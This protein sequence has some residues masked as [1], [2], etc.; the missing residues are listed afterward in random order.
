M[1]YCSNCGSPIDPNIKFCTS[2]GAANTAAS[3]P[4]VPAAAPVAPPPVPTSSA[5][6]PPPAPVPAPATPAPA[7]PSQ[8]AVAAPVN[9]E[10]VQE[11]SG[12]IHKCP[13]CGE[14]LKALAAKCPA[15]GF[16]LSEVSNTSS[17]KEFSDK[18]AKT[19]STNQKI[20]LIRNFP[21]PNAKAD[22][23][24]FL[25]LATSNFDTKKHM[26]ATGSQRQISEAWLSKIEQAYVKAQTLF[27][28][29]KDFAKFQELYDSDAKELKAAETSKANRKHYFYGT[30]MFLMAAVVFAIL[31]LKGSGIVANP[32]LSVTALAFFA[33]GFMSYMYA[34][35]PESKTIALV[36]YCANAVLNIAFCFVAPGHLFHVIIIAACGLG[37]FIDKKK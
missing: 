7:A 16:E 34:R 24:E 8:E 32:R 36:T 37:S 19:I 26:N 29:D 28:D 21:I 11:F 9:G 27:K 5:T 1:A 23:F 13:N 4:P 35:K 15:C 20:E 33:N 30:V 14:V 31:M 2:C 18:L 6:T 17:V 12:K 22:I 3:T 25:V 10:R